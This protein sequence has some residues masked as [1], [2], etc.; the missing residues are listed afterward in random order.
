MLWDCNLNTIWNNDVVKYGV[1][2]PAVNELGRKPQRGKSALHCGSSTVRTS[3]VTHNL[4][5]C[6]RTGARDMRKLTA[7]TGQ[8][9]A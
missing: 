4:F 7:R 8:W 2:A 3:I 5:P 1:A 6:R 9:A